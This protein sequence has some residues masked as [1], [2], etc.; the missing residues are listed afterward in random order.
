MTVTAQYLPESEYAVIKFTRKSY[1][2]MAGVTSSIGH[3]VTYESTG[4]DASGESIIWSVSDENY[5][6]VDDQGNVT[7]LAK[8]EVTVTARVVSSGE[9]AS[10][11]I[12][13]TGNPES[14]I[15]LYSNSSY[16]L[17]DGY[18][19]NIDI[20]KNTVS[21]ISK[22]IDSD[23]LKFVDTD[24]IELTDA[25]YV[26]TGARI[27]MLD[28]NG[29]LIDEVVVIILGD[30]NGDGLVTGRDA[31]GIIRSLLG[32]ETADNTQLRAMDLN[33]DGYVNNRDAAML[34]RYLV[35]KEEL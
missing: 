10:C 8:G 21:E 9:E 20:G 18:L 3:K 19:R 26:G 33:G 14:S 1:S 22:Q 11:T 32:K 34:S 23:S 17:E 28:S 31:S 30:Y 24:G 15:C 13:I 29:G 27:Q 2:F 5:A 7:T 4:E 25:D 35:G 12:K 6:T 16:S